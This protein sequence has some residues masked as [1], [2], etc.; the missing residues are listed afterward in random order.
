[1][2]KMQKNQK[3]IGIFGGGSFLAKYTIEKLCKAGYRLKIGTRKPWLLNN[4]KTIMGSPGQIEIIKN[5][6]FNYESVKNILQNCDYCINFC[7]QLFEKKISFNQLHSEW[8][9]MLAKISNEFNIK[10]LIHVSALNPEKNHPS[11]YMSS[12]MSG[13]ENIKNNIKNYFIIRPSL[14]FG[15]GDDQF[16]STFGTMSQFSP[17]IPIPG[18]GKTLFSPVHA[19]DCADAIN[20]L[21]EIENPKDRIFEITGTTNY[22]FKNLVE[23]FLKEIKK[24]KI[25]VS[26]PWKIIKFQSYF[27]Q[28]FPKPLAI[29]P[30]QIILLKYNSVPTKKF[31]LLSNLGIVP[32]D[33]SSVFKYW[34]RYKTGGQFNK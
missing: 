27:L 20:K 33:I 29:S 17:I 15:N 11:K 16:F 19:S 1:M 31:P 23:I 32:K 26:V 21:L 24:K 12:K 13:E 18:D 4:I 10:K 8:P 2:V 30:D 6:I 3:I 14:V 25:I 28:Y 5:N 22:S 34:V 7:G 9:G